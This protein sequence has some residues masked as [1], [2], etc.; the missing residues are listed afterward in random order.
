MTRRAPDG[1]GLC[2]RHLGSN[3]I[4]GSLPSAL[5]ALT[6]LSV[7]CAHEPSA[8]AGP[9]RRAANGLGLCCRVLHENKI[10]GSLPSALSALTGLTELCAHEP[11][12]VRVPR[13]VADGLGCAA[14]TYIAMRSL[15]ASPRRCP[16]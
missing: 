11:V 14:G 8:C 13:R 7:L 2:R 10:T 4:T 15:A 3:K 12:A 1:L 16:P 9:S 6:L 5:S